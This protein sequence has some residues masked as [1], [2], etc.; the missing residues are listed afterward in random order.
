MDNNYYN[1]GYDDNEQYED[2]DEYNNNENYDEYGEYDNNEEYDNDYY[3]NDNN[4]GYDYNYP[5][6]YYN[7]YYNRY[8]NYENYYNDYYNDSNPYEDMYNMYNYYK[9][10]Y[11]ETKD[12]DKDKDEE[13]QIEPDIEKPSNDFHTLLQYKY[14][15]DENP[16]N[17]SKYAKGYKSLSK[18]D[19]SLLDFSDSIDDSSD[20]YVIQISSS[21]NFDSPDTKIIK[22][23]TEKKYILQNLKLG[24]TIYYRG[25]T[26]E[27]ELS[28]S[29]IY[30]F[31]VN[32]L[33]PRNLDIPGVD[34]AR[35][36]GGYKT[37][38]VENGVVNQGLIYRTAKIDH[39]KKEGKKILLEDFGIKIE[40][41]LREAK[42]NTGTPFLG[43]IEY[44]AIPIPT[45]TKAIRFDEFDEIYK[46]V[47][48]F[49]SE[50]DKKPILLHCTAGADRTGLMSFSLL[51]LLGCEY[52]D[53]AKDY[54][55]T[56]FGHQGKRELDTEFKIWWK[57]L[58]DFEGKTTAEKC[59]NWLMKKGI[60]E[61]TIEHIRAIFI[62]GYKENLSLDNKKE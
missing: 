12:K 31:T 11:K 34:N 50:A 1:E 7:N 13:K 2:N 21:Q 19:G 4:Y 26:E 52:K 46:K 14:I 55:F 10:F 37:I 43:E 3:N 5:N 18:P 42:W 45:G 53:I 8:N 27:N 60:E 54:L 20:S 22:D 16:E 47:Y 17:I 32:N 28:S 23:L 48:N 44:Y 56:N 33:P 15:L 29:K 6:Y 30:K 24:Q 9:M 57:K 38:L 40:I 35:D 51:S 58:Q 25:A 61:S 36:L 59:K 41:D 49:I 62:D 39:I